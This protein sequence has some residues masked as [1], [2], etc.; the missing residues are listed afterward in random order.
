MQSEAI[1]ALQ[2]TV[3]RQQHT[4]DCLLKSSMNNNQEILNVQTVANV[5]MDEIRK[6]QAEETLTAQSD[7][8]KKLEKQINLLQTHQAASKDDQEQQQLHDSL[9]ISSTDLPAEQQGCAKYA[10]KT[11]VL[12][13][14]ATQGMVR[15]L[16]RKKLQE[17]DMK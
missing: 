11:L 1:S 6:I 2:A 17:K 16:R 4:I 13:S 8:L 5:A 3:T 15:L 7:L 10:N 12:S 9:I 14:S